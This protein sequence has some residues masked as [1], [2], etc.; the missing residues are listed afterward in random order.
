MNPKG[1]QIITPADQRAALQPT[2]NLTPS[3]WAEKYRRLPRGQSNLSDR[4]KN[5][6]SPYSTTIMDLCAIPGLAQLVVIKAAQIGASEA[7]R[8]VVGWAAH[9]VPDPAGIAMPD[10]KKG[11]AIVD[12]R[13]LPLFRGTPPLKKLMTPRSADATKQQ[14]KLQNG[15]ILHL[16]WSGSASS[17]ASDPMRIGICDEVDKFSPWTHG[18]GEPVSLVQARLRTY[19]ERGLL[20]AASTPSTRYGRIWQLFDDCSIKVYFYVPCPRCGFRQ[21]LLFSNLKFDKGDKPDRHDQADHIRRNAAAWYECAGCKGRI[22]EADKPA[23]CCAGRYQADYGESVILDAGGRAHESI[24][25]VEAFAPGTSVG[26]HISGLYCLWLS[27]AEVAAQFV[28]AQGSREKMFAFKTDTLG[29]PFDEQTTK[30]HADAFTLKA[31]RAKLPEGTIP[32]WAVAL[33]ATVDTQHRFFKAVVR[34]WGPTADGGGMESARIWH[35][36]LETFN[37]LDRMLLGRLWQYED[38]AYP[39]IRLHLLLIDTGGTQLESEEISRTTEVYKWVHERVRWNVRAIKGARRAHGAQG[40]I[41]IWPAKAV[42]RTDQGNAKQH[43]R[44]DLTL[45][46]LDVHHYADEL[47]DLVS[48]GRKNEAE[49]VWHLNTRN[50]SEYNQELS[51]C[52]KVVERVGNHLEEVWRPV[53]EGAVIDF[54]DCEVYQ[55]A[56]A[57]MMQVHTLPARAVIDARREELKNA[58]ALEAQQA[59]DREAARKLEEESETGRREP[60]GWT[61]TPFKL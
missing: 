20:I 11:R 5:A 57:Y 15:F 1:N 6:L 2:E 39:P 26:V 35:G 27:W 18:Q 52:V 13:I 33:S 60:D 55:V 29:E 56:A 47:A 37:D 19:G 14:V 22:L 59:R 46:M 9:L 31:S 53:S 8:N 30:L 25:T 12:N 51:N 28:L 38:G 10:E 48:R 45:W 34:A 58:A 4:Y 50:D 41:H 23:M 32:K 21:R 36:R 7:L 54:F 40:A 3:Q 43:R 44:T 61:P 49:E 42:Q 17:M 24:E 16:M